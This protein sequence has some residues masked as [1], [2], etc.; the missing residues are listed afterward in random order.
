MKINVGN[1]E[2]NGNNIKAKKINYNKFNKIILKKKNFPRLYREKKKQK[3]TN[4]LP[5]WDGSE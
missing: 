4:L 3:F 5:A 1:F 2:S